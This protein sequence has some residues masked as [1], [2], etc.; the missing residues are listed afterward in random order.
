MTIWHPDLDNKAGPKYRLIVEAIGEGIADGT[1]K[2]QERLP[3]QRKLADQL[4]ISLNTVSRAYA[5]AVKKGFLCGEVG[6]GTYVRTGGPLPAQVPPIGMLRPVD[7]PIDFTLN[8]PA[9]G[10]SA[11][12]LADTL[13][14]LQGSADLSRYLDY[15]TATDSTRHTEAAAAWIGRLGLDVSSDKVIL[16]NGAQHALMVAMLAVMRPGD[17]LL[18]ETLTYAPIKVLAQHLGIELLPVA[19][20]EG[21]LSAVALEEACRSSAAKVLYC[22]PTLH[23]PT[24]ITMDADR[25]REITEIAIKH[26]L[27]IIEDDVFGFMPECRPAPLASFAPEHTLFIT[28]VSKC[29]APG[30][31]VGYLCAPSR[32][33][34]ALRAAVNLSCWMPPPLMAEIASIWIEEGTADRLN[35]FQRSE[36]RARQHMARRILAGSNLRADPFGFHLWLKLP[37]HWRANAFRVAAERQGVKLLTGET[38]TVAQA[39]APHAVRLCLS[40][41]LT[42]GRVVEGLEIVAALLAETRDPGA[43][44]F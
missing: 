44:I 33:C 15:H 20:D 29:L 6:R 32:F 7:G 2:T 11:L 8:L 39:D 1:L 3:T 9:A 12:A 25:R 34:Q 38:F 22:L 16:T 24:T 31:R 19:M 4:G 21:G 10:Q 40:H 13:G 41:E 5:E 30:L 23:T 42:R 43:L 17:A 28:S 26:D 14:H 37:S 27:S 35:E 18:T 36:S